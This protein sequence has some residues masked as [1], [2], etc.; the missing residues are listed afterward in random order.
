[1]SSMIQNKRLILQTDLPKISKI[2]IVNHSDNS[3][4]CDGYYEQSNNSMKFSGSNKNNSNKSIR[5]K[6]LE[7]P[8]WR[9]R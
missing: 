5:G 9:M 3:N 7:L 6:V 4:S 2:R 1:M 8:V